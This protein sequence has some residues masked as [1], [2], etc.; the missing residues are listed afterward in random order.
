MVEYKHKDL[1]NFSKR[2][3]HMNE[4]IAHTEDIAIKG[5]LHAKDKVLRKDGKIKYSLLDDSNNQKEFAKHF[6]DYLYEDIKKR[7]GKPKDSTDEDVWKEQMLKSF[8][9]INQKALESLL[10]TH[11]KDFTQTLYSTKLIPNHLNQLKETY[12]TD[13]VYKPLYETKDVKAILDE[14]DA[15]KATKNKD[16]LYMLLSTKDRESR[17]KLGALVTTHKEKGAI[18][19]TDLRKTGLESL[20]ESY[21]SQIKKKEKEWEKMNEAA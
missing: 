9:G 15:S 7:F 13:H 12:L 8:Y 1:Q 16:G 11:G 14:L 18:T 20:I 2:Y 6:T 17:A 5:Y 19:D 21:D 4:I 3:E 10:A